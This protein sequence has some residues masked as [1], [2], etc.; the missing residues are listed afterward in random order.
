MPEDLLDFI[1]LP[2]F[3]RRWGQLGLDDEQD[4]TALQ[5][6]IMA[7]PTGAK[8]IKGTKAIRKMRFAPAKWQVGKSGAVRV[9]YV[10]FKEFGIVLLCLAYGKGEVANISDAVK[11]YLNKLVDEQERELRRLKSLRVIDSPANS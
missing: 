11:K 8:P 9:L 2:A 5:L 7:N 3:T 4:L 10:Y 6:S 1:E